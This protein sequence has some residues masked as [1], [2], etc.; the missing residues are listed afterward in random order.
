MECCLIDFVIYTPRLGLHSVC[1]DH[2]PI[3]CQTGQK[4]FLGRP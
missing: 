3:G 2:Q 1:S 4:P